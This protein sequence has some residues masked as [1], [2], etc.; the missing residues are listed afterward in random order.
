MRVKKQF[1]GG[2]YLYTVESVPARAGVTKAGTTPP[3]LTG[4]PGTDRTKIV[5]RTLF[6]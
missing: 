3:I 5:V 6:R 1:P 2:S 4:R